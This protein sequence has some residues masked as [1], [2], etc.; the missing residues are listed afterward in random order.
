[1]IGLK[2]FNVAER[3][4]AW[5]AE[6]QEIVAAN[7]ANA[8]TPGFLARDVAPFE[9]AL[10]AA[11]A[12]RVRL[13]DPG[14]LTPGTAEGEAP[15]LRDSP[16]WEVSRSGNSVVIEQEMLKAADIHQSF[17]LESSVLKSFHRMLLNTAR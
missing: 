8:N 5:L 14:H 15:G 11:G 1:M 12:S 7:I 13:T 2:L 4:A 17:A 3:H 10:D 6:R 9:Q 16:I